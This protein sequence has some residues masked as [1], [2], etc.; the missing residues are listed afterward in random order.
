M[1]TYF[2][3]ALSIR[4]HHSILPHS[5]IIWLADTNYRIDPDNASVH[6]HA[7]DDAL[8]MLLAVD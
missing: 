4:V 8:N 7:E 2:G 3:P 6:A 1:S 5:N